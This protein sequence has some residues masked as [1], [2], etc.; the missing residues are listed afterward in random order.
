MMQNTNSNLDE[1]ELEI[2]RH[3]F[4]I[5]RYSNSTLNRALFYVSHDHYVQSDEDTLLGYGTFGV[6]FK[7]CFD[8]KDIAV[9]TTLPTTRSGKGLH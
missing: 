6:V 1:K 8:S 2:K 7:E 3:C 9:K 5:C 4:K